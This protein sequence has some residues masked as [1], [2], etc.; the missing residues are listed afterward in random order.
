M[1][2][3]IETINRPYLKMW[4]NVKI[5]PASISK[6]YKGEW[7]VRLSEGFSPVS[8][9]V[10]WCHDT[11]GEPGHDRRYRW[12]MNYAARNRIFLRN[13]QDVLMFRLRWC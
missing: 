5:V 10:Q 3:D 12:R 9:I 7:V 4:E 2:I 11:M 13:E 1:T 8:D 6:G